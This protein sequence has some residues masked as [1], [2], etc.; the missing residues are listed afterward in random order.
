MLPE[1]KDAPNADELWDERLLS[2][3]YSCPN[4]GVS[5]AEVEPRIFS[6]NSPYGACPDCDGTGLANFTAEDGQVD[7]RELREVCATCDGKRLRRESLSVLL[8]GISIADAAGLDLPS[9]IQ[10]ITSLEFASAEE[11]EIGRPIIREILSRVDFLNKVGVHYLTLSRAADTLS[12]GE[13]QRV[14]LAT[15][16]GSGLIGVC[17]VLDEPS[18]GLHPADNDRLIEAI[19]N[20]QAQGNTVI[21]VEHDEAMMRSADVLID[22]GPRSGE[23]G[24]EIVAIGTPNDVAKSQNSLTGAYLSNRKKIQAPIT[25]RVPNQD[26]SIRITSATLNNLQNVNVD[27]P[28][29]LLVCVTGPSGSGKSTLINDTLMAGVKVALSN[30]QSEI[31]HHATILGIEHIDKL[32]AIDQSPIG[33]TA[34]SIPATYCGYGTRS[35][36]SS[37]QHAM[38]KHEGSPLH[39]L[40]LIQAVADVITVWGRASKSLK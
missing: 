13:L 5:Y 15:S 2:T 28:L 31:Q 10:W 34:R 24:G 11:S 6:F 38:R 14:R 35:E 12:G 1:H 19:R 32:I 9:L 39:V 36:R 7:W 17:Y 29:G 23:S 20:L 18:I 4:C 26:R 16:I 8:G 3:K 27:I 21:V 37:L 25:Y 33:R 30:Q 40:A 22:M